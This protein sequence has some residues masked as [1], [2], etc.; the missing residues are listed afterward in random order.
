MTMPPIGAASA[1]RVAGNGGY[2]RLKHCKKSGKGEQM[3]MVLPLCGEQQ[4]TMYSFLY[5][6]ECTEDRWDNLQELLL[7][8]RMEF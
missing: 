5:A 8:E 3:K 2:L 4:A 7:V 6:V 1:W